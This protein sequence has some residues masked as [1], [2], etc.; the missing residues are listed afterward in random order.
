MAVHD[1]LTRDDGGADVVAPE[2]GRA[3][4]PQGLGDLPM[5]EPTRF[6]YVSVTG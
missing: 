5:P 3:R 2:L 6:A 1:D 4:Q